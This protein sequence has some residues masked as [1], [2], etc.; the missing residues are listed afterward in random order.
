MSL[1]R[2]IKNKGFRVLE[3]FFLINFFHSY[4]LAF[5][6]QNVNNYFTSTI[7]KKI[8]QSRPLK[9]FELFKIMNAIRLMK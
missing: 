2:L 9:F 4:F 1:V 8:I 7:S 5:P 3:K 6:L